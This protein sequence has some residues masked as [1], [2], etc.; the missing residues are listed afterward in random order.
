[1]LTQPDLIILFLFI[2]FDRQKQWQPD[3]EWT[4]QFAGAVMY[5]TAVNEKWSPP[6][7]NGTTNT[8]THFHS[9]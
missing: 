8:Q 4:E 3:V 5:P 7:W 6:P 9:C 1:M 2:V